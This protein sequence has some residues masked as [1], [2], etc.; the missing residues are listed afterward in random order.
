MTMQ[1]SEQDNILLQKMSGRVAELRESILQG[2]PYVWKLRLSFNEFNVLESFIDGSIG[3]HGGRHDHLLTESFALIVVIY[4]AEWYKRFYKGADTMDENKVLS[5]TTDELKRLYELAGIDKNTFVYNASKNPDKT[6]FRW[7]ESLQVLGGLAVQAELKRDKTDN[8][9]SQLCKIFHGEEIDLDDLKDRNRAVAFQESIARQHSLYEYLKCILEK[10]EHGRRNLPFA[11]S[12]IKD[13][14]TMIPE[15][16]SRIESADELAKKHKFDFEW[17]IAYSASTHSMVRHLKVKLKPEVIGGGK[18]QYIGYD[19]LRKPEWGIEAPENVGRIRFYLRFKNGGHYIQKEGKTEEPIFKY[20]NTG[21]E[22]TGFLSVNK[23]DEAIYTNVPVSRFDKVE[24]VMKYGDSFRI[25]QELE[26]K[27]YMQIY[28]VSKSGGRKFTTR[29][30]SQAQTVVIFSSAHHLS[31]QYNNIPVAYAH[32][33]NGENCGEDY[34]WCPINDKVILVLSTSEEVPFFNRNGLYQVVTK[35]YLKTIKYMDNVFVLYKYID[36]DYDEEEMQEDNLAVLFGRSGL[37]VLH[38]PSG[39]AKEGVPLTDYDLEWYSQEAKRYITWDEEHQPQQGKLRLRVTVK[40]I[41]FTPKVYYVPFAPADSSQAPI[42]RDFEK[43]RICT[44][45][46]GVDDIQDDFKMVLGD[47]V[48]DTKQLEIGTDKEKILVD[49]Y[50]P[51]IV[52]ELSQ[53]TSGDDESKV[54]S[55]HGKGEDI[56]IPLINCEQFSVRDF[57]ENGVKEYQV[58]SPS[59]VYYNFPSINQV[60]LSVQNYLDEHPASRL[61]P[62]I[63]LDYLKIYMTKALDNPTDLYSWDYVSEPKPVE[64]PNPAEGG[65]V[66]QSLKDNDSPRHYAMPIIK[67]SDDDGWGDDDWDD[68]DAETADVD[69]LKCYETVAEHKTYFFL[70]DPLI[71]VVA[72]Q[73]Q[74]AEILLP[75]IKARQYRLTEADI[76]NLYRFAMHFHFDWMLLPR[77]QWKSE[78]A[79]F[80]TTAE[81][82]DMLTEAVID[83]F[84]KTPKV[85]DE[86]EQ[87]SLNDFLK[88]Y[89]TFNIWPKVD[90]IAETALKLIKDDPDALNK[91]ADLKEFLK[92]YDECRFKFIEM[93]KAISTTDNI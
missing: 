6:S 45:L 74:I 72:G 82:K 85:T 8:L 9:L 13:E 61:T 12:D 5:L 24:M 62:D 42:W 2:E 60:G 50:R 36:T 79:E 41:V 92:M 57:S 78:I 16:I 43:M 58:K 34:C 66:F 52:H 1:L 40:G 68:D 86:R 56:H 18:K 31:E 76:S 75:L 51:I 84:R 59:T 33:R 23:E 22:K 4:L 90:P 3:S 35:K 77:D 63:P 88:R 71:K 69:V 30:N 38:Y 10:D 55:Y 44:A 47:K 25:V 70:F 48:P 81:E 87:A 93:S 46:D 20:D 80:A 29:K 91:I 65:I 15:L 67:A 39:Q 32:F 37:Q 27:D 73:K 26:V 54:I 11:T 89:W 17:N 28:E 14:N 83:F 21:S 64:D 19:R 49:V 7:Q 53:R